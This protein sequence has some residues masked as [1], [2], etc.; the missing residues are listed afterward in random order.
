M[1]ILKGRVCREGE[2]AGAKDFSRRMNKYHT[3]FESATGEK[4]FPGTLNVDVGEE[5]PI[6]EDFRIQG[7]EINEPDQ[8]L[9]FE[10]CRIKG[11]WAYRIRPL[12]A[13]GKGGHGDRILEI[14]CRDEIPGVP[15]GTEVEITLFR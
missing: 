14:T 5:I 13:I 10:V 15:P 2:G 8:D 1:I 3:V 4:L 6:R 12:D 11:R 9:L 7:A